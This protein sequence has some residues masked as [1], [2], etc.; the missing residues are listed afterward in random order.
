MLTG[1]LFSKYPFLQI[2]WNEDVE[3][4]DIGTVKVTTCLNRFEIL[5]DADIPSDAVRE[6]AHEQLDAWLDE[7]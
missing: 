7:R 1:I 2:K 6:W 4:A 3:P 5:F